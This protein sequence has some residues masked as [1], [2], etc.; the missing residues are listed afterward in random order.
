MWLPVPN[1][2]SRI[3]PTRPG[4]SFPIATPRTMHAATQRLR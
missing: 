3:A 4:A 2:M 1:S